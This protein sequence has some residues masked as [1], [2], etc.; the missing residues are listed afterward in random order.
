MKKKILIISRNLTVDSEFI[1]SL[2]KGYDIKAFDD[3]NLALVELK[4]HS[5]NYSLIVTEEVDPALLK[6]NLSVALWLSQG[7]FN[8]FKHSHSESELLFFCKTEENNHLL[9]CLN[10]FFIKKLVV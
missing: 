6:F 8:E 5:G 7:S 1:L 3:I 4:L 9:D 2:M 10:S